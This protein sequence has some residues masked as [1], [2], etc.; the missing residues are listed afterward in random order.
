MEIR[1][2]TLADL[3]EV[4]ALFDIARDFMA[5]T[6]NPT[7][8]RKDFTQLITDD[9]AQNQSFVCTKN[10][11]IIATFCFFIGIDPCYIK[12]YNGNWLNESTYGT[13]HRITAKGKGRGVGS[14]CL[15]YC[16]SLCTNIK[17]D[18]HEDNQVMQNFLAKHG[19]KYC[20]IIH[21]EDNQPRLAFQY[22]EN[23]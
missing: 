8:W 7:Q 22:T 1:N 18:T 15:N 14:F 16:K 3:P 10:G 13:I 2:T 19:F 23:S 12:I 9:I 21:M 20:G 5:S 11:E 6:G 17:I 4:L